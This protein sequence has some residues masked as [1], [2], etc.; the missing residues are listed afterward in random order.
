MN[1]TPCQVPPRT[2]LS[3]LPPI[4]IGSAEVESLTSYIA[5]L[6]AAHC[7]SPRELL[8]REILA[9]AGK[10]SDYFQYSG[11]FTAYTING[12]GE[13]A[14]LS[15]GRLR[16]STLQHSL[17]YTTFLV[18]RDVFKYK[19]VLRST[20]AWCSSCYSEQRA[21]NRYVYDPLI[22]S[23]KAISMCIRHQ[24]P[25]R[26]L[27]PHC[28]RKLPL[29]DAR[30]RPGFCSKC[31]KWLGR[32][33]LS[34]AKYSA[35]HNLSPSQLA[36]QLIASDVVGDLL[37]SM[38]MLSTQPSWQGFLSNLEGTVEKTVSYNISVFHEMD[39]QSSRMLNVLAG[40]T[41]PRIEELSQLCTVFNVSP[42][43]LLCGRGAPVLRKNFV[44]PANQ[45]NVIKNPRKS[46]NE[47]EGT[48]RAALQQ[49]VPTSFEE[50][51][52]RQGHDPVR[53]RSRFPDLCDQV[54][55]K[56]R[57]FVKCIHLSSAVIITRLRA[58]LKEQP[59]PPL[60]SVLDSFHPR[61]TDYYYYSR[62]FDACVAIA[63]R[64]D[65][66][67][68]RLTEKET[69]QE[70]LNQALQENPAPSVSSL[71]NSLGHSSEF[72]RRQ[73]P[74]LAKA[75][76]FRHRQYVSNQQRINNRNLRRIIYEAITAISALGKY[77]S[78]ARIK[79]H[80]QRQQIGS[81]C[82]NLFSQIVREVKSEVH[83]E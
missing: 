14:E 83:I 46:L 80:L 68:S 56:H 38:P 12:A 21:E 8:H 43:E 26:W 24:E 40:R 32:Q 7:I 70:T 79:E 47:V 23:V 35:R 82:D 6:A 30:Y 53:L 18:W 17:C 59:P 58:A 25:L 67:H 2:R 54:I 63:K 13:L 62:H 57:D 37:S 15:V 78:E 28:G 34:T 4:G 16:Q 9:P 76:D 11:S 36:T 20:R 19:Q 52:R 65:D 72:L 31:S 1:I 41:R 10:A 45:D 50:V 66:Y 48:L 69:F 42:I 73:Y 55:A 22:W 49:N 33:K 5:R 60:Q 39:T 71:A 61:S 3:H 75:I 64:H 51:A 27:C 77:A 29:L 74:V 44:L 81:W